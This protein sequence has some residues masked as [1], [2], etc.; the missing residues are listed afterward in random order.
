MVE[1]PTT[2]QLLALLYLTKYQSYVNS[3]LRR[4]CEENRSLFGPFVKFKYGQTG[5]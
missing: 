1:D 2:F 3:I 4:T 5:G